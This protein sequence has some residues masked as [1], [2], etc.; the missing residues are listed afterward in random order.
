MGSSYLGG[1]LT[2]KL[3]IMG[4]IYSICL[5]VFLSF[6]LSL[7]LVFSIFSSVS[8]VH[9]GLCLSWVVSVHMLVSK[10]IRRGRGLLIY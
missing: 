2:E 6:S 3:A 9:V 8:F 7:L 5:S 4:V 1:G 10:H